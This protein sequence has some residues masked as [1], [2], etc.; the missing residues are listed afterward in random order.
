MNWENYYVVCVYKKEKKQKQ[1][2]LIWLSTDTQTQNDNSGHWTA[3]KIKHI[4]SQ[5]NEHDIL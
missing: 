5:I 3:S 1:N 2:E 4:E